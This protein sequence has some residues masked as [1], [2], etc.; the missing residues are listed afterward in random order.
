MDCSLCLTFP[1]SGLSSI[2]DNVGTKFLIIHLPM[3][4]DRYIPALFEQYGVDL[5]LAGHLHKCAQ[6]AYNGIQFVTAGPA[7]RILG[8]DKSG[9][10]IITI[11]GGR[12]EAKY[13]E[14]DDIP[15]SI[16]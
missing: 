15:Q 14:I 2:G 3:N 4:S 5:V 16:K 6:G 7:G 12:A 9:I 13:Y 11:E 1:S 10:E 8:K